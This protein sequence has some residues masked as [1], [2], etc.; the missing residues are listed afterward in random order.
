M[1]DLS[2]LPRVDDVADHADLAA[3]V[4]ETGRGV[5]V[6]TTREVLDELRRAAVTSGVVP[7]A[8]DVRGAVVAALDTRDLDAMAPVVNAT[9]V[10]LHTNLGRAPL[11]AAARA[12]VHA[13]ARGYTTVELDR[14]TGRRG[15]RTAHVGTLAAAIC[16]TEAATVVNNGAAA[17]MLVLSALASDGTTVVS[18]GEQIEIGGSYR[19][20]D[21]I[22][23]T[24]T[25][26]V[27]VGT[28]NR[29]HLTDYA[30]AVAGTTGA[31]LLKV[32]PSNYVVRGFTAG[33]TV[34]ELAALARS[35]DALLVVDLGSGLLADHDGAFAEEPSVAAAV[36]AG[37]D[38]VLCSGDKLLGGPQAGIVAGRADLVE[39]CRRHPLARAVRIDKLQRAALEATLRAHLRDPGGL[40]TSQPVG[41]MLALTPDDLR[42][43]AEAVAAGVPG[44]AVVELDSIV[45][46]G[47][48]PGITLPSL[49]V[50][51][52]D[53]DGT[54]HAALL[55]AGIVARVVDDR[56]LL[57]L[58]TVDPDRDVEVAA[59]LRDSA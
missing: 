32:H 4:R 59:A 8:D 21:V 15:S 12:A 9:G 52:D 19:L 54:V 7:T 40:T 33:A 46:G 16:G 31:V 25:R 6:D 35:H 18:R 56:C 37:A 58:R 17:L 30:A 47:S 42:P 2:A 36:R 10:V 51:I 45:G 13:A 39:R 34:A 29:T 23:A 50:A 48:L 1:T 11:S 26:M 14:T 27:E 3:H 20:P 41:R 57:D 55:A 5:V 44:A 38:L 49:G 43:R 53:R 24:G 22:A 28:T